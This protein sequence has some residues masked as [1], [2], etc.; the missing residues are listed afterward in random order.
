MMHRIEGKMFPKESLQQEEYNIGQATITN[1][2]EST[3]E[4][5]AGHFHK[6]YQLM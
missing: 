2:G 3:C 4:E 6:G 1:L 5:R